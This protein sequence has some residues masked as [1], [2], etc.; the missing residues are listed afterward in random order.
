MKRQYLSP[1]ASSAIFDTTR[2]YRY[3]LKR[4]WSNDYPRVTFIML[5][6]SRADELQN[7]PTISRC[8]GFAY[9]WGCGSLEVVNL[10]A[11]CTSYP[12]EL[13]RA[14]DPIGKDNDH[15]LMQAVANAHFTVIAWGTKG[16][17]L[18]RNRRVLDLLLAQTQSE[19]LYY[20]GLTKEGHPCHPLYLKRE[21]RLKA[22]S[23][24]S[25]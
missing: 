9:D 3:S 7:D 15:F 5:N 4:T 22:F 25:M 12:Y 16:T 1:Y 2:R 8:L 10:F 14:N 6:P 20:L 13:M 24:C 11:Y 19:H 18:E 21:T 23:A 17:Y